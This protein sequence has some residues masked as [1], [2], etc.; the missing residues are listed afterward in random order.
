MTVLKAREYTV[1]CGLVCHS[2][3]TNK[4]TSDNVASQIF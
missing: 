4:I 3:A 1:S 2:V